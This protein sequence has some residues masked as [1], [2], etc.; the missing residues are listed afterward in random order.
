MLNGY[1]FSEGCKVVNGERNYR[2]NEINRPSGD[3]PISTNSLVGANDQKDTPYGVSVSSNEGLLV[4]S[5]IINSGAAAGYG[6][7]AYDGTSD[8][9][10]GLKLGNALY[11]KVRNAKYDH[12]GERLDVTSPEW[13]AAKRD[14]QSAPS[15]D[16]TAYLV[17]TYADTNTGN[18]CAEKTT[19]V[20]FN[21]NG[22]SFDMT[23][24]STGYLGL[25][26][27]YVS[28]AG[29]GEA[30][31]SQPTRVIPSVAA[32]KGSDDVSKSA[33]LKVKLDVKE[34]KTDD[35]HLWA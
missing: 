13:L 33:T 20:E 25:S 23:N 1:A 14:D 9:Q 22:A 2:I 32:V 3:K 35:Y 7:R 28:S 8:V 18:I 17:T 19:Y 27:R 21:L 24:Y 34:Y 15:A 26:A 5:G 29:I 4:L 16:N 30:D 11:G 31:K 12:V 10:E 6:T